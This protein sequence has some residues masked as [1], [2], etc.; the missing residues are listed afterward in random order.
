M[1]LRRNLMREPFP[2]KR[3]AP[4]AIKQCL[5]VVPDDAGLHR[6]MA[7]GFQRFAV[8]ADHVILVSLSDN[9]VNMFAGDLGGGHGSKAGEKAFFVA[10]G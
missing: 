5:D 2:S 7:Y 1:P 3:S 9:F 6:I 10:A 8:L 4:S